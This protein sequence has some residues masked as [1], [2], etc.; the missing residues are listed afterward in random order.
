MKTTEIRSRLVALMNLKGW[1]QRDLAKEIACY[2]RRNGAPSRISQ[3]NVQHF[4]SGQVKT[5]RYILTLRDFVLEQE[6][7]INEPR[8][9]VVMG[10]DVRGRVPLISYVKAGEFD[11]ASDPLEPGDAMDWLPCP[12]SHSVH[13]FA[14]SVRGDS[15]TAPFGKSYPD[16]SII[17]IDPEQKTPE[18]G[19]RIIAKLSGTDEV[20][21]KKFV[22]EDGRSWL[23]PLNP[24]HPMIT[25]PFEVI[26]VVIGKWEPED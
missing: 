13:T 1:S 25:A 22:H 7:K 11:P 26:G 16:G 18:N 17:F 12:T 23:Q 10:P 15:M 8:P 21:F 4:I 14:L 24:Q 19:Q 3:Q 2:S 5:P 6:S 20:T 9:N